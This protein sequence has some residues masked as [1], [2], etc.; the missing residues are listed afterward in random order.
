MKK[1]ILLSI[2]LIITSLSYLKA[3]NSD[4]FLH[5]NGV[6]VI[7]NTASVGDSGEIDRVTY[8]KRNRDQIEMLISDGDYAELETTCTSGITD[9]SNLFSVVSEF[10][11]DISHWDVS[12][13]ATMNSM[14]FRA[15]NFSGNLSDWDVSNVTDMRLMFFVAN[16]FN[17]DISNWDVSSVTDMSRMFESTGFNGDISSWNTS[18]VV[19]MQRMFHNA[20]DFNQDINSWDVSSVET[21]AGMF[22]GA[23]SFNQDISSWN[24]E[25]VTTMEG[26]FR[27]AV[28]FNQDISSWNVS[29]V[30]DMRQMFLGAQEFNQGLNDWDVSNV[31]NMAGMF[32]AATVFNGDITMW[33]LSSVEDMSEMFMDANAF[34]QVI[35][36]QE[37]TSNGA[38]YTAWN[39]GNV[40]DMS[41]M[42][43]RNDN[44][45]QDIGNWDVS[46]VTD[47]GSMFYN[48]ESFG[49]DLSSWNTKSAERFYQTFRNAVKFGSDLGDWNISQATDLRSML[50]SSGLSGQQYDQTL[51][52]WALQDLQP[53]I[54][55]GAD[56][57]QFCNAIENRQHIINTFNWTI[58]DA[59][60]ADDCEVV[61]VAVTLLTPTDEEEDVLIRPEFSWHVAS[62]ADTYHFELADDPGFESIVTQLSNLSETTITIHEDLDYKSI[63]YWRVRAGNGTGQGEWSEIWNFKTEIDPD[64][65]SG[66]D[67]VVSNISAPENA[68]SGRDIVVSWIVTN[69]GDEDT[70]SPIWYD[71]IFLD[72]QELGRVSNLSFLPAGDTYTQELT[73]TIPVAASGPMELT[74]RADIRNDQEEPNT[75]NNISETHS[76]TIEQ[77]PYADLQVT[78]I[79]IPPT[80]F[81][82]DSIDIGWTVENFGTGPAD[83][84]YWYDSIFL[85]ENDDI[86]F[87][88]AAMGDNAIVIYDTFLDEHKHEGSLQPGESYTVSKRVQLPFDQFGELYLFVYTDIKY[89]MWSAGLST[90]DNVY[91]YN[92]EFN[93]WLGKP[94]EI[95]LTP[96]PDLVVTKINTTTSLASGEVYPISWE[97][98]N[99]GPGKTRGSNWRDVV[100]FSDQEELNTASSEILAN[101][102]YKPENDHLQPDEPYI[103]NSEI[104]I[105]DGVSGEYYLHVY[106]DFNNQ[107]FEHEFDDNNLTTL[108]PLTVELS[109]YPNLATSSIVVPENASA[110]DRIRVDWEIENSGAVASGNFRSDAIYFSSVNSFNPETSILA[111]KVS[112]DGVL[113]PGQKRSHSYLAKIPA[114]IEG[115][116]YLFVQANADS[117]FF[118]YPDFDD[119]I[120]H[121]SMLQ[122][123]PYPIVDLAL[124]DL[125]VP[126]SLTSGEIVEI[127]WIVENIGEGTTLTD[128]WE[129]IVFMSNHANR[130]FDADEDILLAVFERKGELG[131][132]DF[133][134]RTRNVNIPD[135]LVGKYYLVVSTNADS[136]TGDTN[137]SNNI[138]TSENPLEVQLSPPVDL[139]VEESDAPS[140]V[141]TGQIVSFSWTVRNQGVGT[142]PSDRWFDAVYL[143]EDNEVSSSDVLM[144]TN[145]NNKEL[146]SGE[147]Y[148]VQAEIQ[149]PSNITGD[150]YLIIATDIRNDIYEHEAEDNN[151]LVQ[152]LTIEPVFP[153]DLVLQ[154]VS[155]PESAVAGEDVTISWTI[156]NVGD[157]PA[158]G[159]IREGIYVTTSD[160]LHSSS[161]LLG[162]IDRDID[163]APGASTNVSM[164]VDPSTTFQADSDGNITAPLPGLAPG[165]YKV[166]VRTN[167]RN[168]VR[169]TNLVNN[170]GFSTGKVEV[171]IP[172]ISSGT[173]IATTLSG[174]MSRYYKFDVSANQDVE[175]RMNSSF[176]GV[177]SSRM[178]VR[179]GDVPTQSNYDAKSIEP[180]RMDQMARISETNEGTYYVMIRLD[181]AEADVVDLTVE[182]EFMEFGIVEASPAYG[183]DI[184][185]VTTYINGSKFQDGSQVFLEDED[186]SRHPAFEQN[187]LSSILIQARFDL[188]G[189]QTGMRDLVVVGPDNS[190]T[191]LIN[192]FEVVTGVH[193]EPAVTVSSYPNNVRSNDNFDIEI[194]VSNP[195]T[196]NA[197]DY[198]LLLENHGFTET[199]S[200]LRPPLEFRVESE[201]MQIPEEFMTLINHTQLSI[202]RE[203][204]LHTPYWFYEIAP[205]AEYTF[206]VSVIHDVLGPGWLNNF[207]SLVAMPE[208][209]FTESGS[210]EDVESS[211]GFQILLESRMNLINELTREGAGKLAED[212]LLAEATNDLID[213]VVALAGGFE[214]GPAMIGGMIGGGAA[215]VIAAKLAAPVGVTLTAF[216]LG[217]M[218]GASIGTIY[219]FVNI[220]NEAIEA[221]T[222]AIKLNT[223]DPDTDRYHN[224][225]NVRGS[226]DPNDII[227]PAGYGDEQWIGVNESH[228]YRIRYEND[229]EEAN[230]PAQTVLIRHPLDESLDIRSFRIGSYGFGDLTFT[231]ERNVSFINERLDVREEYGLYVDVTAGI[232]VNAGEAFWLFRSLDPETLDLPRDPLAGYLPVN[233]STGIGEGFVDYNIRV[234]AET[235][236]GTKIDAEASIY[237]DDNAPIDTPPIFNTIDADLPSS[238]IASYDVLKD[239]TVFELNWT[240]SDV[241]AGIRN[242]DLYVS[243]DGG[244]FTLL[245]RNQKESPYL[246]TAKEDR[247]YS[248]FSIATDNAGNR[249]QMKEEGDILIGTDLEPIMSDI[250]KSFA[251]HSNYPNPFN[252]STTIPYDLAEPGDVSITIYNVIGQRILSF[253]LGRMQPGSHQKTLDLSPFASGIYL[254]ELTVTGNSYQL[255]R[256]VQAMTLIK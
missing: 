127:N 38:T 156:K 242:V 60:L 169:E 25:R 126:E 252:P 247:E 116:Y 184:G 158:S 170:I 228:R 188:K 200:G 231:P 223:H 96:P 86:D 47:F 5:E 227:G 135:G 45:N 189:K 33:N 91:E 49:Q 75:E 53:N 186:G 187:V 230:A 147:A 58:N 22:N 143:S 160:T 249:E 112:I 155:I 210:I 19:N 110:G 151:E 78:S 29:Q 71:G 57:L 225:V 236:T 183:G 244:A 17:S 177:A 153:S 63:Y 240:N 146:T 76:I 254:I 102:S 72:D 182:A 175:F 107:I 202:H 136:L 181:D 176:T 83:V 123:E 50:H 65:H 23:D 218:V 212:D 26:M 4:F 119:N 43:F 233:D 208:S 111:S 214:P 93:N 144:F 154:N 90:T 226:V 193:R 246:F 140:M 7:C 221:G 134:Q 194:T 171:S 163:L 166:A 59:G 54:T 209:N 213:I 174:G 21:M 94:I 190:E 16:N 117:T 165:D 238:S 137:R 118:E 198:F 142:T 248:F 80:A 224:R 36:T 41:S 229:P 109:P 253:Q 150:R 234:D 97:V 201:F 139:I 39:V 106:T 8:T 3:N 2:I 70:S 138:L 69:K 157:N 121:S 205:G 108:G 14:F 180:F 114:E 159:R 82:G 192:G 51:A 20:S 15:G 52:G 132:G 61:P 74:V 131:G 77:S 133:Y 235:T 98:E 89:G 220:K 73:I 185:V 55:F 1:L 62:G 46:N 95:V 79:T 250:P 232:D 211:I 162:I 178:Y 149:I 87:D 104:R 207:A 42:F 27:D 28:S 145:E 120:A 64:E 84:D 115:E 12:S 122:V 196:N 30:T 125:Q 215:L 92:Y 32:R 67:L 141:N 217:T 237:F 129:D 31:V 85:S 251:L 113:Q 172:Q 40:T 100:F 206:T 37:V 88:F 243:V 239:E 34:N 195:G 18:N 56:G 179:H 124:R 245:E 167:M 128:S 222:N 256:N 44:F 101:I 68:F 81:S 204:F 130:T 9:M 152:S 161:P 148:E 255:Y 216:G 203:Y 164:K 6:T 99:Q 10:N 11:H 197:I 13:V 24:T 241:G 219:S 48:A 103:Q 168:S 35:N 191:K 173:G 66:P 105:P 199:S